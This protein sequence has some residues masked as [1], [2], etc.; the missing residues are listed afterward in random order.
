[1]PEVI[2][3]IYSSLEIEDL[4]TELEMHRVASKDKQSSKKRKLSPIIQVEKVDL[5]EPQK[6]FKKRQLVSVLEEQNH[7]DL[8][9]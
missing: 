6:I 9:P 5:I 2:A 7:L 8:T 3:R 1:M 4:A